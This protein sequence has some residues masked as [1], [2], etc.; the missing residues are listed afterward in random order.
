MIQIHEQENEE[1]DELD[2][3]EEK[4]NHFAPKLKITARIQC[5]ERLHAGKWTCIAVNSQ[6]RTSMSCDVQVMELAEWETRVHQDVLNSQEL[7][8]SCMKNLQEA[9]RPE[10]LTPM[11]ERLEGESTFKQAETMLAEC[12]SVAKLAEEE[13]LESLRA[14]RHWHERERSLYVFFFFWN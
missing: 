11:R 9:S 3:I 10:S 13:Y 6:G 7:V 8:K 5:L 2:E 12:E 1:D 14:A 4:N